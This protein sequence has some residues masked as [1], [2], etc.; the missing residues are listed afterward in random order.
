VLYCRRLKLWRVNSNV[1]SWESMC[2]TVSLYCWLFFTWELGVNK[3]VQN[4]NHV[5][6]WLHYPKIHPC[7]ANIAYAL[8]KYKQLERLKF[9]ISVYLWASVGLL[10]SVCK[11]VASEFNLFITCKHTELKIQVHVKPFQ[12]MFVSVPLGGLIFSYELCSII[13]ELK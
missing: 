13:S 12:H 5:V 10:S 2:D 11:P 9:W 1:T 8:V 6:F 3:V 7:I 4:R